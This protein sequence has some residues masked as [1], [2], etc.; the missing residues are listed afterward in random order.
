MNRSAVVL[1]LGVLGAGLLLVPL[2]VRSTAWIVSLFVLCCWIACTPAH[3]GRRSGAASAAGWLGTLGI[4]SV[5]A[6]TGLIGS[7][8]ALVFSLSMP[9]AVAFAILVLSTSAGIAVLMIMQPAALAMNA[10]SAQKTFVSSHAQWQQ[11]L[12]AAASR[13]A[14][15]TRATRLLA[16]AEDARCSA[17]DRTPNGHSTNALI[18]A[19]VAQLCDSDTMSDSE[20][21]A[22]VANFRALLGQ[23]ESQLRLG[24]A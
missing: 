19:A 4:G 3:F 20:F 2:E 21:A 24:L 7:V 12:E 11:H 18:V 5:A 13:C 22:C 10:V 15:R 23:R 6:G 8:F 14:D 17:R 16:C 1:A 9:S